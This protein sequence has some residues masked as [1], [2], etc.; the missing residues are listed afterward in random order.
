VWPK[1]LY[2]FSSIKELRDYSKDSKIFNSKKEIR[3][4]AKIAVI[5]DEKLRA[6][7]N[8][9][10]Y[11]YNIT[12]FPDIRSINEVS[13][14]DVILCD[15]MGIGKNF[16][17]SVGGAS[18]IREIKENFPTKVVIAYTGARSNAAES[19]VAKEFADG[20]IKKDAEI[21]KLVERL[22]EAIEA[23]SDPYRRWIVARQ[24]LIDEEVDIRRIV[25]LESAY[26][27][28]VKSSD[29]SF[30]DLVEVSTKMD[31]SGHAKSIIQNLISSAIYSFIFGE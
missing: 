15:L 25:E 4:T 26:V 3:S 9:E 8:L 29:S 1:L 13:D 11:G 5:D 20:F 7:P 27:R 19:T 14:F 21:S 6:R 31:I 2:S 23:A 28:S 17:Q 10:T 18:I 24:G 16:D 12:E 22:D 30:K